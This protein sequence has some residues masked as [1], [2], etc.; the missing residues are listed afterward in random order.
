M[1]GSLEQGNEFSVSLKVGNFL[2][3]CVAV[4]FSR[5]VSIVG[6]TAEEGACAEVK[7][8]PIRM[9]KCHYETDSSEQRQK[10][11]STRFTEPEGSARCPEGLITG[12]CTES[13]LSS[14]RHQPL[15]LIL[16]FLLD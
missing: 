11:Y 8:Y 13:D 12:S 14:P 2:K 3:I 5:A 1:T 9:Q 16:L 7:S 6:N 10:G 4:G 15:I